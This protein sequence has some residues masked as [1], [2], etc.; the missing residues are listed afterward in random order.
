MDFMTFRNFPQIPYFTSVIYG[1]FC[2][3]IV[4]YQKLFHNHW[5]QH[6]AFFVLFGD[7]LYM[8]QLAENKYINYP[9][10]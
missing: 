2:I 3:A 4:H 7:Y 6:E 5:N 10:F 9:W 1:S 8:E